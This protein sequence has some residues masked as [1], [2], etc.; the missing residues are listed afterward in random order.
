MPTT[1]HPAGNEKEEGKAAVGK[2]QEGGAR[3][4]GNKMCI[5]RVLVCLNF[6]NFDAENGF[7]Q[8]GLVEF[9]ILVHIR[10]HCFSYKLKYLKLRERNQNLF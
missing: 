7:S 1:L 8:S 9:Q 5:L 4:K 6:I 3:G 2:I 10:C